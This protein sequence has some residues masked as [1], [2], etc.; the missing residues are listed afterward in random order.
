M[1]APHTHSAPPRDSPAA[2]PAPAA[3]RRR[4]ASRHARIPRR[5][6]RRFALRRVLARLGSVRSCCRSSCGLL[7]LVAY[8]LA[9]ALQLIIV[10][11]T[12]TRARRVT[13]LRVTGAIRQ[14]GVFL[15]TAEAEAF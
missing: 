5:I 3:D 15:G 7:P 2:Q 6:A 11:P 14:V 12:R 1:R 10:E 8:G 9:A 4:A 13:Q